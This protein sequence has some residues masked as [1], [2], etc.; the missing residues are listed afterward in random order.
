M[1]SDSKRGMYSATMVCA[2]GVCIGSECGLPV[3]CT[4]LSLIN[5]V[6]NV[7]VTMGALHEK[8]TVPHACVTGSFAEEFAEA[9]HTP[10]TKP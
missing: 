4:L 10:D 9:A 3:A 2:V 7:F 6:Q 8:V 1:I 5:A